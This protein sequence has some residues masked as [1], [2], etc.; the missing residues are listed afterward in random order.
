M[1]IQS[2]SDEIMKQ[3]EKLCLGDTYQSRIAKRAYAEIQRL[4]GQLAT[5]RVDALKECVELCKEEARGW[6]DVG[7]N[8]QAAMG[9][10]HAARAIEALAAKG[11][12]NV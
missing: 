2:C 10:F 8:Q 4:R 1:I 11:L 7:M 12:G 3:L 5:A 9:V 6:R